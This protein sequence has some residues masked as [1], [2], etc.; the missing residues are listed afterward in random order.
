MATRFYVRAAWDA[1]AQAFISVTNNP[2]LDVEA[3]S[4]SEF[5]SLAEDL[6]PAM[7]EADV[8]PSERAETTAGPRLDRLEL[9]VGA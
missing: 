3:A 5:L 7:V 6:A 8:P 2:G 9:E 1:E 4:L